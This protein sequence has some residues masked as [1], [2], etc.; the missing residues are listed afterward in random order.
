MLKEKT[1]IMSDE[2]GPKL[3]VD[4]LPDKK[5]PQLFVEKN[6]ILELLAT[7]QNEDKSEKFIKVLGEITNAN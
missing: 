1:T 2:N 7:F 3:I 5:L 4:Q 6:G